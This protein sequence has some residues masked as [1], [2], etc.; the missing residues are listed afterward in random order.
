MSRLCFIPYNQV[1]IKNII[2][3]LGGVVLD[4]DYQKTLDEFKKLGVHN[5]EDTFT[6]SSQVE[7]FNQLDCGLISPEDFRNELRNHLNKNLS[8]SEID[9]AW[10]ALLLEWNPER[11]KLLENLRNDYRIYLLSNT[12][13]IHS[14]IYNEQ[15]MSLSGGKNLKN[16]FDKVY[17]SYEVGLRKPNPEIFKIVLDENGLSSEN[18]LFIDDTLEHI[19]SARKI[20]LM[21]YH[22][23]PKEGETIL[24]LFR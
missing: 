23:K 20:G 6:L 1:N 11:I 22:I 14:K 9:N 5:L 8:D 17:Y 15:L 21:S 24:D 13:I 7:L 16:Y 3:D 19:E 10:N 4:I 12:N 2:F 18:T